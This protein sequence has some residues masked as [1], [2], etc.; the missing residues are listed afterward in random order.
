MIS[1]TVRRTEGTAVAGRWSPSCNQAMSHVDWMPF[2]PFTM[3]HTDVWFVSGTSRTAW[4]RAF[5]R[6]RK[7]TGRGE[8]VCV[9]V[10]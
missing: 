1:C 10:G 4:R 6:E 2:L 5:K 9:E 3:N 8:G 7:G